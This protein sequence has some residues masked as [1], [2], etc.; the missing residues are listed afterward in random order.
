MALAALLHRDAETPQ[1]LLHLAPFRN[2]EERA[3]DR[4]SPPIKGL[5]TENFRVPDLSVSGND[6]K[7]IAQ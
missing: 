1:F 6:A 3:D 7:F 2:V 4:R 5:G